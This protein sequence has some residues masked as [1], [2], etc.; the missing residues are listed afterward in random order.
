M[1][2][3]VLLFL[4]WVA[5]GAAFAQVTCTP[6]ENLPDS[7]VVSPLPFSP[8]IPGS[9]IMDTSCVGTYFELVLTF[10]VPP[11]YPSPFGDIP[12]VSVD[13]APQD[14]I[15]N[16][17]AGLTYACNPPD[18]VFPKEEKGCLVIYGTPEAG[19][20]GI[21]DLK[22]EATIVTSFLPLTITMPDDLQSG[23][24]FLHVE[25]MDFENCF[26]V[27]TREALAQ[28][29]SIS[30]RPNPSSGWTQIAV[31]SERSG[32]FDLTV[33]DIVGRV[34]YR[35]RVHILP[36][37][38]LIDFDGSRLPS[39]FYVYSISDGREIASRKMAINRR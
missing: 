22:V 12:L 21:Y 28:T 26:M 38:N 14:A 15:D 36:G 35:Q 8:E 17:P 2:R 34:L 19:A 3:I 24:Y 4:G 6:N 30:N 5:Y 18:C 13:I 37:E 32:D 9:G 29:F 33:R 23:N 16:L 25:S 1:K 7:V 31:Q 39:G 10:N 20:E 27:S 11:L